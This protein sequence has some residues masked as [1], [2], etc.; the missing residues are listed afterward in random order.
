MAF[1]TSSRGRGLS[2]A[3]FSAIRDYCAQM[4]VN[5][6]RVDTQEENQIMQHILTRE[7]FVYCGQITYDAGLKLAYELDW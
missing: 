6:I 7:G 2:H 3:A 4:G 5:A 1:G